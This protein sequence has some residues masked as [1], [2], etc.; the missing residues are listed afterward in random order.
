M[1][2]FSRFRKRQL[3]AADAAASARVANEIDIIATATIAYSSEDPAHPIERMFD[4]YSGAGATHWI[5]GRDNCVE[6]IVIEFD[7]PQVISRL[8]YEVEERALERTQEVRGEIS[9]DAGRSYR[10]IFVQDYTFS[11]QGA[12]F[13]HEEQRFD[14]VQVDRLRLTIVPNK[15]GSGRATL[16]TLRLFA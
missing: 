13:Q 10:Q 8:S 5:S 14:R 11:P 3:H 1:K 4:G 12:T 15:H 7:R 16:T 2:D 6:H 9:D